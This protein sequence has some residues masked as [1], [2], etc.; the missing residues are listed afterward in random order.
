MV[1]L[2]SL[3]AAAAIA[4]FAAH[5]M[6]AAHPNSHHVLK[7]DHQLAAR[8]LFVDNG[9]RLLEQCSK[10]AEGRKLL[11]KAADRRAAMFENIQSGRRRLDLATD[12]STDHESSLAGLTSS[13]DP[14]TLF[15]DEV[16]CLLEP[17]VT[18]GPYYVSG[19]LIRNDIRESQPGIDLYVDLQFIDVN[20]C[21]AVND[22][23]VDFWHANLTGVYSGVIAS[24]NGNGDDATNINNTFHRGLYPTDADGFVSFTT[25]FPGHYTGRATH[26]HILTQYNGTVL[27][28]NT[29]SGSE[30][31]H[32]G[33][34]FF[35]Q[36]LLTEVQ[37]TDIYAVNTW[38]ITQN[39]DDSILA[40]AAADEFDPFVE[41]ARLGDSIE[42]GLLA[43]IS[44]GVDMTS[45]YSV[46]AAAT[47]TA[48][49]G[50]S[51]TT[52]EGGPG[53]GGMSP[54]GSGM[55]FGSVGGSMNGNLPGS[56]AVSSNAGG[57]G[58]ESGSESLGTST[59]EN[60]ASTT[61]SCGARRD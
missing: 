54:G 26:L 32:I 56:G 36:D 21:T 6:A 29:Y 1:H 50:V 9:K 22:L 11:E 17:E 51:A 38:E 12:L 45:E 27:E 31:S 42:D 20:T 53:V 8:K 16:A 48:N 18:S 43:W 19:E 57:V 40:Q 39:A 34:L 5:N 30:V 59:V 44:V 3:L 49:G 47:Y 33:Q 52:T 58:Q 23:Y 46:S 37:A 41:Y 25:K 35:D 15:G 14:S 2:A 10:S 13:V 60:E 7:T 55:G 4:T 61:V 28:N 24:D